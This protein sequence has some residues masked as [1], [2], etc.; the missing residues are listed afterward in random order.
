FGPGFD[1]ALVFAYQLTADRAPTPP[2]QVFPY[3]DASYAF[4]G[5]GL[6]DYLAAMRPLSAKW[7]T[8][9]MPVAEFRQRARP[10]LEFL[11]PATTDYWP[12]DNGDAWESPPCETQPAFSTT[13]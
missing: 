7:K 5:I 11:A 4:V 2:E 1:A 9:S 12:R 6:D 8:V 3:R 13:P 10:L